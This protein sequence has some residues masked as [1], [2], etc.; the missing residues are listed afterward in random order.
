MKITKAVVTAAG[1]NQ[2][3]LPLQTLIDRDGVEKP[4]LRIILNEAISAGV[5]KIGLIV[6]PGDEASY[7]E[8]AGELAGHVTF[9]QQREPL[10]YGHAIACAADFVGPEPF[11]HMVGDHLFISHDTQKSCAR[12]LIEIAMTERCAVSAV[13]ATRESMLPYF[14]AIG[15]QRIA[16]SQHLFKVETVLEKPTPTLAE[17]HLIV[18]GLRAGT[19]LCFFGM[20]VLTPTVIEILSELL[21]GRPG[22]ETSVQLADALAELARREQ[23][24]ALEK[25]DSRYDLGLKYG[26][27]MGQLALGLSG[28][29]RDELLSRLVEMLATR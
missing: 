7:E 13:K 12:D 24:L 6:R 14:G 15:G 8:S 2:R 1:K 21:A 17:Q 28:Q 16:G 18:P 4:V 3:H 29:D 20:H 10:G 9:I 27:F 5:E 11:L 25:V 23:Y 26:L 19:Y 22:E